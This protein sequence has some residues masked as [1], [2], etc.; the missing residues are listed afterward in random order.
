MRGMEEI[1]KRHHGIHRRSVRLRPG[2]FLL[3]WQ[4]MLR[5]EREKEIDLVDR[6]S[7]V[8][9]YSIPD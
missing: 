5:L 4:K 7:C 9:D 1:D 8:A 2:G 6:G 3:S